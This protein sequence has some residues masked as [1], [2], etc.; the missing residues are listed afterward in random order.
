M[1]FNIIPVRRRLF[2]ILFGVGF[3]FVEVKSKAS[4]C[5]FKRKTTVDN[6]KGNEGM[7]IYTLKL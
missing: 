5:L 1:I 3:T 2:G 6:S 4:P 7:G